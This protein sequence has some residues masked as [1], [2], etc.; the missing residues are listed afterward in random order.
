M[1]NIKEVK[2]MTGTMRIIH[3]LNAICMVVAVITGLYIGHPYYQSFIADPAVD[4]YVM[5]WNRWGHFIVAII[6]DVTAVLIGYLYFFSRFEKPYKKLIPTIKNIVE[7]CEVFLNLIT[8]NRRKKFDSTHSD[9]YNIVFFTIFH[10]LLVFMLFSGLQL[11][12]HG[13]ASGESSIGTWWPW[14]LHLV[15]DWTLDVFGGN[16][17]VRIAH[18]TS[19]YLILVWVMCHIYY[20]IWRTIFWKEGDIAIVIGG[21]KFVTEEEKK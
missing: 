20:Q 1:P 17:G 18:H 19:M 16:M 15:T 3:W 4:K 6:F 12:V 5:A 7:F 8:F 11:Y 13:L 9:S 2:R 21:S 14:M 10:L